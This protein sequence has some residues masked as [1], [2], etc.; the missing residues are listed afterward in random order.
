MNTAG[1]SGE[2]LRGV[3]HPFAAEPLLFEWIDPL[4]AS[5]ESA[6]WFS[7]DNRPGCLSASMVF[8]S[9]TKED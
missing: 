8:L 4:P 2:F 6:S 5:W 7:S 1:T 9:D 3:D